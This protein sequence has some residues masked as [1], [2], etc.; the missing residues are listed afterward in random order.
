MTG[1]TENFSENKIYEG[2][3]NI[4][5]LELLEIS[6]FVALT[7][8]NMNVYSNK[9]HE[10]HLRVCSEVENILKIV[11][12]KH[13]FSPE[14][15]NLQWEAKKSSHLEDKALTSQYEDLKSVL[16]SKEK[17]EVEKSLFG[18]PD[19]SFYLSL[20]CQAFHLDQKVV[21]F[22]G[23]VSHVIDWEVIQ[24]FSMSEAQVVPSWWTK[25]NKLKHDKLKNFE[26]CG[27]GDLIYSLSALYILMTY[28]LKYQENNVPIPN[29][30]YPL[31]RMTRGVVTLHSEFC[32]INS[33]FFEA[34][35]A[36]QDFAFSFVFPQRLTEEDYQEVRI[37]HLEKRINSSFKTLTPFRDLKLADIDLKSSDLSMKREILNANDQM[38]SPEHSLFHIYLDYKSVVDDRLNKFR[39]VRLYGQFIN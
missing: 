9:I 18:H 36:S 34:S 4:F 10:L 11:V 7:R 26:L 24:P 31:A 1:Q 3:F 21:K 35:S 16:N 17:K 37:G 25:Y 22:S 12:H 28:L 19:F 38:R 33:E 2:I 39:E 29:R 23:M 6:R 14:E 8:N 13:F 20:A 30:S 32:S 15:V 27:L 5:E